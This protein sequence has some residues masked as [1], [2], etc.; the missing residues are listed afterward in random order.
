MPP[1]DYRAIGLTPF[2]PDII[3][4]F[5][6]LTTYGVL[7]PAQRHLLR[8]LAEGETA[9][10]IAAREGCGIRTAQRRIAEVRRRVAAYL[11]DA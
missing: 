5:V 1:L 3:I 4:F 8:Y 11:H 6:D 2:G 10:E 7:D 9:R